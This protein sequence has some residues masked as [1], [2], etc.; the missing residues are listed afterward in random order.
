M[1]PALLQEPPC[2]LQTFRL[3]LTNSDLLA[4]SK[5]QVFLW[6]G[7]KIYING[8]YNIKEEAD[9]YQNGNSQVREVI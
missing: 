2:I 5:L 1:L 3:W 6:L 7:I 4:K 9:N 8:F